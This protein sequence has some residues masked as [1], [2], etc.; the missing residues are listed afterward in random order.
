MKRFI[1]I[2]AVV[3][4]AV[5]GAAAVAWFGKSD[6]AWLGVLY[7]SEADRQAELGDLAGVNKS[8]PVSR[9]RVDAEAEVSRIMAKRRATWKPAAKAALAPVPTI[10]PEPAPPVTPDIQATI[11]AAVAAALAAQAEAANPLPTP[12]PAETAAP[13][14]AAP[15]TT[16]PEITEPAPTPD[17]TAAPAAPEPKRAPAVMRMTEDEAIS[18]LS[19]YFATQMFREFDKSLNATTHAIS[20]Q[21][22]IFWLAR[23]DAAITG[24]SKADG[25]WIIKVINDNDDINA[26]QI[27]KSWLVFQEAGRAPVCGN[28]QGSAQWN[29]GNS[30]TMN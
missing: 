3:V 22:F 1:L 20:N 10:N 13:E 25:Y 14:T 9:L 15:E 7:R 11:A 21:Q 30:C 4:L 6:G 19:N 29:V 16:A 2:A 26:P 27:M 8:Q 23:S 18:R 12:A 17:P 24:D 28:G 5:I